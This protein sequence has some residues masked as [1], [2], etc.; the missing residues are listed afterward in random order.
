MCAA[1]DFTGISY[2]FLLPTTDV[3]SACATIQLVARIL[4]MRT[5]R[6]EV[7]NAKFTVNR[8]GPRTSLAIVMTH[9]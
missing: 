7:G 1:S 3:S 9:K 8:A 2:K 4:P 5:N 6:T